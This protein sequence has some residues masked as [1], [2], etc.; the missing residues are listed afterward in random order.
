MRTRVILSS[1]LL[2]VLLLM[3]AGCGGGGATGGDTT[4]GSQ[5][6][7]LA[8]SATTKNALFTP[9]DQLWVEYVYANFVSVNRTPTLEIKRVWFDP[10]GTRAWFLDFSDGKLMASEAATSDFIMTVYA[11]VATQVADV[12]IGTPKRVSLV[13]TGN[14]VDPGDGDSPPG[15]PF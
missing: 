10:F 11:K 4:G 3:L 6:G 5:L 12:Q 9:T 14:G 15:P 8:V 1:A 2:A 13:V 7:T